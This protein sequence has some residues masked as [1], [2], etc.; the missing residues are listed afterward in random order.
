MAATP[1][2]VRLVFDHVVRVPHKDSVLRL[3]GVHVPQKYGDGQ[4]AM[5]WLNGKLLFD[6]PLTTRVGLTLLLRV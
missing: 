3:Y 1:G 5:I 4:R 6:A 2:G